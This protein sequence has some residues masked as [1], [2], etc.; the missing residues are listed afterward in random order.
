M[1][2][3]CIKKE[4]SNVSLNRFAEK[5]KDLGENDKHALAQLM[6]KNNIKWVENDFVYITKWF[7][8]T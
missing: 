2:K 6:M 5:V 3:K 1:T 4:V 7:S 8:L